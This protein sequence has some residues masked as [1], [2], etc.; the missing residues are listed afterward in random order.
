MNIHCTC[1]FTQAFGYAGFF[2]AMVWIFSMA[3]VIVTL[4]GVSYKLKQN[5]K[6][7]LILT[8][9]IFS[10]LQTFGVFLNISD[11]I[12]GLTLLAWGNS[13]GGKNVFLQVPP[14]TSNVMRFI[15][16]YFYISLDWIA[17][18]LMARQGFSR[19]GFSACFGAPFFSRT[20][21]QE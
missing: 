20:K 21:N 15:E 13:I 3:N 6:K 5:I 10:F 14:L 16:I 2:V 9:G 11:A 17:D 8:L 12:L 18:S 1:F 19:M 4:L 7:V